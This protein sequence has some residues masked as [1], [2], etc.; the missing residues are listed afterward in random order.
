MI[1]S[2]L[3]E[4]KS[5]MAAL[6]ELKAEVSQIR[7]SIQ[8]PQYTPMQQPQ[9]TPSQNPPAGG[10]DGTSSPQMQYPPQRYR[11][12]P[13]QQRF[14]PQHSFPPANHGRMRRYFSCQQGGPVTVNTLLQVWQQHTSLLVVEQGN[15][16][17]DL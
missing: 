5:E 16:D 11:G 9:Y 6:K 10:A 15:R 1:L 3:E 8:Q 7:E 2:R 17:R 13:A 4:I 12:G 14:G